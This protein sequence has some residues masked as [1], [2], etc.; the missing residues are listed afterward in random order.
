MLRMALFWLSDEAWAAVKPHLTKNQSGAER[1][2]DRR[3]V[4]G[5]LHVLKVGC[6]WFDCPV[7]Y[8]PATTIYNR[9][10]RWLNCWTLSSTPA[11]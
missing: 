5:T 4:Y 9:F 2:D 6:R 11:R 3:V 7:E 1:V 8:G 10:N